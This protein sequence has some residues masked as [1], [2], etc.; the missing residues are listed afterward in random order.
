LTTARILT[1]AHGSRRAAFGPPEWGLFVG[2]SLVWGSSFL[3]ISIGLDAFEP[4]LVTLL[5]VAF[6]AATLLL[7]PK[8][9]RTPIERADRATIVTL[10]ALWVAIPFTLFPIAQQWISSGVAGM[11][12]GF[13]PVMATTISA[14]LLRSMPGR[15]QLIGLAFGAAGVLLVSLNSFG[16]GDTATVG[17]ALILLATV[18]YGFSANIATP[19]Q[20]KYGSMVVFAKVLPIATLMTLPF[21]IASIPASSFEWDSFVAVIGLGVVGTGVAYV[22]MGEIVGRA[23]PARGSMVTYAIPVVAVILGV[24]FRDETIAAIG[25]VGMGLVIAG[26]FLASRREI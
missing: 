12:N 15:S 21:G 23:G 5:R 7:L 17:V 14:I 24:I 3:L 2:I 4:G 25:V 8:P 26:A 11:L 22:M 20:Q 16:D 18:C 9:R 6:G 1:T 10:A 13:M 19:L